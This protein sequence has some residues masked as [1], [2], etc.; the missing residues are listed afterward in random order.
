MSYLLLY[1][2]LTKL[3]V[4]KK[5]IPIGKNIVGV[6]QCNYNTRIIEM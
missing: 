3:T 4:N 2:N 5:Y 6:I 1:L